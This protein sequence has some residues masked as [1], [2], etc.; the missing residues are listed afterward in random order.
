MKESEVKS[1]EGPNLNFWHF[2]EIR[3]H[4]TDA[5]IKVIH[6]RVRIPG[7]NGEKPQ[8]HYTTTPLPKGSW[9]SRYTG[10]IPDDPK[11]RHRDPRLSY[12]LDRH[13]VRLPTRDNLGHLTADFIEERSQVLT[14]QEV[15]LLLEGIEVEVSDSQ[16]FLPS[17]ALWDECRAVIPP[18]DA[19][20]PIVL[21]LDAG[22]GRVSGLADCFGMVGVSR[23]PERKDDV[24]VRIVRKWQ[25]DPGHKL[26]FHAENGPIQT[27]RELC[28]RHAVVQVPYDAYQ[29]HSDMTQVNKENIAWCYEFGQGSPRLEADRGLYD[30]IMAR[31]I[32]HDGN[33][34]LR[35][36][37]ANAG[38][39]MDVDG[40]RMRLVKR[41]EDLKVD[42]AVCLSMAAD[43]CLYLNL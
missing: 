10:P 6:G 40:R 1:W 19:R 25:A 2:D 16:A 12:K 24:A 20:T 38:R 15:Q 33:S 34:D 7:P 18:L 41:D 30:L 23:H 4:R 29:L 3:R 35:D 42:L 5:A 17:I 11:E 31:R 36:H 14:E 37:M 8:R 21:A 27:L 26:D 13:V 43:R 32:A 28:G 9:M 22:V 39:K